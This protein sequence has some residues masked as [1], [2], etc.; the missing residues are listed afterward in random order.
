MPLCSTSFALGATAPTLNNIC[1]QVFP[2]LKEAQHTGDS[3]NYSGMD[4]A[5]IGLSGIDWDNVRMLF[6]NIN[7][8]VN[9]TYAKEFVPWAG[10]DNVRSR[11]WIVP[12]FY[13]IIILGWLHR[14]AHTWLSSQHYIRITWNHL[15]LWEFDQENRLIL[16]K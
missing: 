15:D 4:E 12:S 16:K 13:S 3:Q 10:F 5:V 6:Q 1:V 8:I 14:P 7:L 9:V 2:I 11:K